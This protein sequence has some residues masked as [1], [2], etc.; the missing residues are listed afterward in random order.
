[1]SLDPTF[2]K[3][4]NERTVKMYAPFKTGNLR[5]NA[6]YG[7]H[8]SSKNYFNIKLDLQQATYLEPLYE[9]WTDPRTGKLHKGNKFIDVAVLKIISDLKSYYQ[10]GK[11]PKM[12]RMNK[13]ELLNTKERI[14][15][16]E[17][18]LALFK[19]YKEQDKFKAKGE[20]NYVEYINR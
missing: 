2:L 16:N 9:G 12:M 11:K 13:L 3:R 8:W 15:E 17:K 7:T 20:E 6:I 18:S 19:L 10:T 5:H 14:M 4:Q 1:M